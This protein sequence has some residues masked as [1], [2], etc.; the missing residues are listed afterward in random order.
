[1]TE[2]LIILRSDTSDKQAEAPS[3][4]SPGVLPLDRDGVLPLDRDG[5]LPLDRDEEERSCFRGHKQDL[6]FCLYTV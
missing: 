6:S 4:A 1:V 2:G 3:L 5:V